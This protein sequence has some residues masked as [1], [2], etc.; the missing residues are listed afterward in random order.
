MVRVSFLAAAAQNATRTCYEIPG[1]PER[2]AAPGFYPTQF[3]IDATARL[4]T[5][6]VELTDFVA[7]EGGCEGEAA[8]A[9]YYTAEPGI[10]PVPAECVAP[11]AKGAA[12]PAPAPKAKAP[13]PEAAPAPASAGARAGALALTA[14]A[15][16]ALAA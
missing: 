4:G 10:P 6:Y 14:L 3:C 13:A 15:A 2:F 16:A 8:P 12:A 1:L 9:S 5:I 7:R 11:S